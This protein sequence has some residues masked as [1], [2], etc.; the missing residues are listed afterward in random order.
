MLQASSSAQVWREVEDWESV[1]PTHVALWALLTSF[2]LAAVPL[3]A[4]LLTLAWLLLLSSQL[5]FH[6]RA[7]RAAVH[8]STSPLA[9]HPS[10]I[11]WNGT[12]N[13]TIRSNS[14]P[15]ASSQCSFATLY[16]RFRD[17]CGAPNA[18]I[19]WNR[20]DVH[21]AQS[22]PVRQWSIN[23]MTFSQPSLPCNTSSQ[24]LEAI[25]LGQRRP[26]PGHELVNVSWVEG[27]GSASALQRERA[28]V[29]WSRS[30]F[31]PHGCSPRWFS[32]SQQC[33]ILNRYSHIV[34]I[35]DSLSRHLTQALFMSLTEDAQYGALPR[36]SRQ[37]GLWDTCRCDGQFS[38]KST[39]RAFESANMFDLRDPRVYGVCSQEESFHFTLQLFVVWE[40]AQ[41]PD[42]SFSCSDDPRPRFLV[43]QAAAHYSTDAE[44][45]KT[46]FI[47]PLL[48]QLTAFRVSCPHQNDWRIV[49]MAA[50]AQS[51]VL[52]EKYP[53]QSRER[54]LAFN[55]NI[56]D[57]L[58]PLGTAILDTWNL[59]ANAATSDGFH[60]L[61]DVNL[62]RAN[63]LL[64]L[65]YTSLEV[66][67]IHEA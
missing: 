9:L 37:A 62:Q 64:N 35:G 7:P 42:L 50:P 28:D 25:A 67:T 8:S 19:V 15:V 22:D 48:S 2:S 3:A 59:T 34:V 31:V 47:A 60:Y 29:E 43:L 10:L 32:S 46:E 30:Y 66:D 39:C 56:S 24:L 57:Y 6:M 18:N 49:W 21:N 16:D 54:V 17:V 58:Q 11:P 40:N 26:L 51:R 4:L 55:K 45:A 63:A 20:G 36:M 38:E 12:T 61:S 5:M 53:Q 27:N 44:R 1:Y 52:D 13:R 33:A 65:L 41:L 14:A 23:E